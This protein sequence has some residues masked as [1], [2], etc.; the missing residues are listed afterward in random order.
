VTPKPHHHGLQLTPCNP[1]SPFQP[2][3]QPTTIAPPNSKS[4]PLHFTTTTLLPVLLAA[5]FKP[6]SPP[7]QASTNIITLLHHNHRPLPPLHE[8]TSPTR[9][10][11]KQKI[12]TTLAAPS[13]PHHHFMTTSFPAHKPILQFHPSTIAAP[14]ASIAQTTSPPQ[15]RR[16]RASPI[17]SPSATATPSPQLPAHCL[18]RAAA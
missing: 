4:Q 14:M 10:L 12:H 8:S 18:P 9:E 6:P 7:T 15:I 17:W 3:W 13:S 2:P 11:L 1:A 5:Q 16:R